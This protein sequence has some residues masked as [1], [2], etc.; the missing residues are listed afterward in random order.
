MHAPPQD[1]DARLQLR[2]GRTRDLGSPA[3][4]TQFGVHG[5]V[6]FA[7]L[8]RVEPDEAVEQLSLLAEGAVQRRRQRVL[9]L[10]RH[11]A[12]RLLLGF[13]GVTVP[14]LTRLTLHEEFV[15][16]L[17]GTLILEVDTAEPQ[18]LRAG[19]SAYYRSDRPHLFRNASDDAP[20]RLI[21]V[22]SPPPL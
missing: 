17:E 3:H 11:L 16:V 13:S 14:R 9:R 21:C 4:A 20:L 7:A 18:E 15:H 10:A 5:A 1:V 2:D 22:D 6:G 19:D 12:A 8:P